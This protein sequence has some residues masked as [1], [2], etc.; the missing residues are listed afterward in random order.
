[1][2][3][4]RFPSPV[5]R[6]RQFF[7]DPPLP[8]TKRRLAVLLKDVIDRLAGTRFDDVVGI[9][10]GEMEMLGGHPA[11]DRLAGAHEADECEVP[12]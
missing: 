4:A 12:Y 11:G 9:Q 8:V 10:K 3:L 6:P 7:H 5:G 1:L 2:R